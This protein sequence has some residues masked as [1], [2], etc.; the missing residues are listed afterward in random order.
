MNN[1]IKFLYFIAVTFCCFSCGPGANSFKIKIINSKDFPV[2]VSSNT[3]KIE[4]LIS[5]GKQKSFT[6]S[7]SEAG[8]VSIMAVEFPAGMDAYRTDVSFAPE[9]G[10][11]YEWEIGNGN[12]TL[13]SGGSDDSN[14]DDN[15]GDHGEGATYDWT[16]TCPAGGEYTVPITEGPCEAAQKEYAKTF[17]CNEVDNMY[18]ACMDYHGCSGGNTTICEA[19]K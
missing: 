12:V 2:E 4:K 6:V 1:I 9:G 17:G 7:L 3:T 10:A 13:V 8:I 5:S 19:Y 11:T 15:N 16:F 18:E 14:S